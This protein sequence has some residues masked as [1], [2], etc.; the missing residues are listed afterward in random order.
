M[1]LRNPDR[2][3]GAAVVEMAFVAPFLIILLLGIV[4]FGWK[5]GEFNEVRHAAREAARYAAVSTP[6]LTGDSVFDSD[7]ILQAVCDSLNLNSPNVVD[8]TIVKGGTGVI[9]DQSTITVSIETSSLTGAPLISA[10]LPTSLSNE[11]VF[12]LE[13]PATW[14]SDAFVNEC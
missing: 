11:A 3:R 6:D 8:V 2:E 7:D 13:Q 12:R 5:F 14:D 1:M 9:G 10:F 4:E